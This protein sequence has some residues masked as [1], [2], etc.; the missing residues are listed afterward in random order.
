[1]NVLF[2][3]LVK[4]DTLQQRGIYHDLMREFSRHGH[5]LYIVSPSERRE[6]VKTSIK[7]EENT[8]FLNVKTLNIQK[9][10]FIEKGISTLT[11]EK[12]FLRAVKKYFSDVKFDLIIYSTPP[13]TFTNLIKYIKKRDHAK[14]YLLLKDIFPQNAVD[15]QL[16][17]DKGVLYKYFRN[18]EKELYTIS[19]KIGCMSKANVDFVLD[20]NSYISEDKTEINPNSIEIQLFK[21]LSH[22]EKSKIKAKYNIPVDKMIFIYGGNL[23]KPQGI[24]FLIETLDAKKNDTKVFFIVV[25]SGTEYG[26]IKSWMDINQPENVLFLSALPKKEYDQLV[27]ACDVGLIF[28]HKDFKI[29]NYPSRLLS[30]L[31]FKMPVLA[32]TDNNTDIGSDIVAN[33]CGF[34]VES[35][36]IGEMI[37][38]VDQLAEM[39]NTIFEEMRQKSFTFLERDFQ[40]SGSYEKIIESIS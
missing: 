3:T 28:L 38:A 17:S 37:K 25:G 24:D 12:L 14:T 7:T 33:G 5:H 31:E 30:Y 32:A 26:K 13:I 15:M 19:D 8:R 22:E 35:G 6:K 36:N 27:Q 23:G 29:P 4:I 10:N 39:D 11:I 40:V 21:E 16:M 9:T 18:K 2:L 20:H 1:M 34:A